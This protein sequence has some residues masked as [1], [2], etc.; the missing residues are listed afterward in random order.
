MF[1]LGADHSFPPVDMASR[2]GIIAIGGDL[3]P[4][5][6]FEA[7]NHGIFPWYNDNEPIIWYAPDPR[8]VLKPHE[9]YISKSMRKVLRT[10]PFRVTFNQAFERV[11]YTCKTIAR[12][13][14]QG[15]WITDELLQS[16]LKL[17]KLNIAKSVEVWQDDDLV[18]GL[19]GIDLGDI[20]CGE[21][22][23]SHVSNA[24]KV[25]FI[26]L[27][28]HLE[29]EQYKLLDCQVYNEHLASLGAYE[30]PRKEFMTYLK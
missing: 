21:S 15:T 7:Y 13:G 25:A 26:R 28:Q 10:Q 6:L 19:Y 3:N 9:V 29:Q 30:I 16:M 4:M 14:E 18:G 8:M 24:S 17:H 11:I 20:F 22:M 1:I 12:R 5:R 27:C 2:D 23:F